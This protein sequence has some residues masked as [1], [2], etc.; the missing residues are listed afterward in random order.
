MLLHGKELFWVPGILL[1][2]EDRAHR[3]GQAN[4]VDVHY[5]VAPGTVDE[6]M[7]AAVERRARDADA[8]VDG[9]AA[10][11]SRGEGILGATVVEKDVAVEEVAKGAKRK[12]PAADDDDLE[13]V[14][15]K[16]TT[17]PF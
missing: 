2:A 8:A 13:L 7:F 17:R 14:G 15:A 5:L 16:R 1:Q 12:Q 11:P 9:A 10:K 4:M 3:L 6:R